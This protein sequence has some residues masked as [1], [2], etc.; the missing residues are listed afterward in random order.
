MAFTFTFYIKTYAHLW[1]YRTL[2]FSEWGTF[3]IKIV[4]NI[5]AQKYFENLVFYEVK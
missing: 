5:K 4:E 2:F 1:K 3:Q